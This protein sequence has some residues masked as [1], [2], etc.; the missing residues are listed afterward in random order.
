[1]SYVSQVLADGAVGLF[2]L[3]ESVTTAGASC[4]DQTGIAN[5][6]YGGTGWSGGQPGLIGGG[7][8]TAAKLTLG[9][10]LISVPSAAG[11]VTADAFAYEFW[12]NIPSYPGATSGLFCNNAGGGAL[13]RITTGG[14]FFLS[15]QGVADICQSTVAIPADAALHHI[16]V[17]KSGSSVHLWLD[18]ADVT[19]G[20]S[21]QTINSS[22]GSGYKIA[23][24]IQSGPTGDTWAMV[25]IY[26]APLGAAKVLNHY[27]LGIGYVA[28]TTVLVLG[29]GGLGGR[30]HL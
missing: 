24:A 27:Q 28:P 17:E 21:N 23:Q 11:N 4:A 30:M 18:S 10:S 26:P 7:G 15:K 25:A 20:V 13:V 22:S 14:I 3:A 19:G 8:L 6:T 12:F 16:V 2:E 9:S 29:P 1:M 5:T